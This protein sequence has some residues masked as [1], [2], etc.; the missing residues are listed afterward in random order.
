[1]RA[2]GTIG[3]PVYCADHHC[4]HSIEMS[5]E[6]WSDDMRLSDI[7]LRLVC[8]AC[9]KR[10]ADVR[11]ALCAGADGDRQLRWSYFHRLWVQRFLLVSQFVDELLETLMSLSVGHAGAQRSVVQD[12]L[13]D[14]F[15]F[16]THSQSRPYSGARNP[17]D[18]AQASRQRVVLIRRS[19]RNSSSRCVPGL[20]FFNCA[21]M[22]SLSAVSFSWWGSERRL[23]RPPFSPAAMP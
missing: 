18:E 19:W 7:E 6:Q 21:S 13:I 14:L 4:S 23:M 11:A 9:G 17:I 16:P 12:H 8:K 1:M 22:R 10:G 3:I 5:A 20:A 2:S 15:A